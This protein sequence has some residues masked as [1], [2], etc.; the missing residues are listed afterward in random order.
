YFAA[1][2]GVHG[3]ELWKSDGTTA[4][5]R[6]VKNVATGSGSDPQYLAR[7]GDTV[8]FT[9]ADGPHG[10]ELWKTDGTATGTVLVEAVTHGPTGTWMVKDVRAG[11]AGSAIRVLTVSDGVLYF[12]ARD[13]SHGEELWKSDGTRAGTVL[14]K[15]VNSGAADSG[16]RF[17]GAAGGRLYFS[18]D[19]G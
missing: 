15:D 3:R 5:T 19:D 18:A 8:Y 2:D 13:A 4:G 17:L 7:A 14:V 1:N 6:L 10:R 12:A 16:L 11:A 9:A